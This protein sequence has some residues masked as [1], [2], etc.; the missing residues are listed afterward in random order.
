MLSPSDTVREVDTGPAVLAGVLDRQPDVV[1]CDMQMGQMGGIAV[2]LDMRLEESGGRIDHVPVLLL[3]D[4]R[5][6]VFLA[7]RADAEG[8]VVKPL[9][10]LQLRR[11]IKALAAGGR[12]E[13]ESYRPA[14]SAA[15]ATM[16]GLPVDD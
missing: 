13:D 11:A 5:P 4:R 16:S 9:Q 6:D 14:E 7:K 8:W 2:C 3:I 15:A 12:W 10:P 1:V